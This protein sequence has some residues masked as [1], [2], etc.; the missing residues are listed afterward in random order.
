MAKNAKHHQISYI[1]FTTPDIAA[2]KTFYS[3]VFGW[4]FK[5]WGP[6]YIDA[7]AENTGMALGFAKSNVPRTATAPLVVLYSS[8]LQATEAAIV[9]AG[10]SIV[11]PTFEFPG[12]RR[13][14]FSD[15]TGNVLA[16]W[17]E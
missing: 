9:A 12:G 2:T 11:T 4:N 7:Q 6:D 15:G 3:T 14:H 13:F 5:D 17:S 8:D 16:V 1:E 10:G